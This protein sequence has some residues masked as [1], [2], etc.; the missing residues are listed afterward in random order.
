VH[1]KTKVLIKLV[2]YLKP[3]QVWVAFKTKN[4]KWIRISLSQKQHRENG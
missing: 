4:I 1:A 2:I 3:N